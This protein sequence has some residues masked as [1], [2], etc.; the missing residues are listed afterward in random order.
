MTVV[1]ENYR[2][3]YAG[4]GTT[5]EFAVTFKFLINSD[6]KAV[7]YNDV[8]EVETELTETTHY[9][10]AG[11][12][13]ATGGTLTM[14][15]APTSN[16]TLTFVRDLSF[17]QGTDYIEHGTFP[18][19]S[20]E[21]ALDRLTMIAQQLQEALDRSIKQAVS[22]AG[23]LELPA[24]VAEYFLRWTA[25]GN[26]ENYDIADLGAYS[27]SPF[28]A[29]VLDDVDANAA[30]AT[31]EIEDVYI[32]TAQTTPDKTISISELIVFFGTDRVDYAGNSDVDLGTGGA[33]ET[34]AMPSGEYNKVL[35]TLNSSGTLV[36]HEGT[37]HS[38]PGGVVE[39]TLPTNE[40]PI[41]LVLVQDN[42]SEGAG[43]IL[44]ITQS[45]ITQTPRKYAAEHTELVTDPS[46]QLN[47]ELDCQAHS[48]G[49]TPQALTGDGTDDIDWKLGNKMNFTFG[50]F[51]ETFTFTAPSKATN[52]LLKLKQDSVGSR[53]ATWPA[54][55]EWPDDIAPTLSTG[56]NKIDIIGLYYDGTK[57]YGGE[58]G[59][60]YS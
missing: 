27:V 28:M 5:V 47:N 19:E 40:F 44:N 18:A 45:A 14:V 8:T 34:A 2:N 25:S 51:N 43:T 37:R 16:E 7:L 6:V 3:D 57:Y 33:Y 12:G 31:L 13:V 42:G 32:A 55:V 59:L 30:K 10:L 23:E 60:N 4:N 1:N 53:T 20:H 50:A 36:A 35:F 56:A 29:T 54:S 11:A 39:P 41:C 22:Q 38:T 58:C 48:V 49:F 52:L 26:L 9:T 15:T 17:L 21:E 46:P 24:P